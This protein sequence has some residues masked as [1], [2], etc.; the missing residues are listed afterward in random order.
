MKNVMLKLP[1]GG[2]RNFYCKEINEKKGMPIEECIRYTKNDVNNNGNILYGVYPNKKDLLLYGESYGE[3][4]QKYNCICEN[5]KYYAKHQDIVLFEYIQIVKSGWRYNK[6]EGIW[7]EFCWTNQ[8][9]QST[10]DHEVMHIE[11]IRKKITELSKKYYD[12]AWFET[13]IEC[14]IQ[15]NE[16]MDL[17]YKEWNQWSDFERNHQN[18]E[19]KGIKYG[20][21]RAGKQCQ[22]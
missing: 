3:P 12:N 18:K 21:Y 20:Q 15:G 14:A 22:E 13:F 10:Y 8:D 5:G 19:W 4:T 16:I 17:L 2:K 9:I 6:S 11:N 7:K 1:P